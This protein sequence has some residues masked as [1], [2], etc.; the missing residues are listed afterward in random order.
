MTNE[1][2][3]KLQAMNNKDVNY[4]LSL[5]QETMD[6]LQSYTAAVIESENN[7][8]DKKFYLYMKNVQ[9]GGM[10]KLQRIL[11]HYLKLMD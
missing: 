5:L 3:E 1:E 4:F 6:D 11:R 8:D 9:I 10:L 7:E 2:I